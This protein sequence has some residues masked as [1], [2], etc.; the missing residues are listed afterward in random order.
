MYGTIALGGSKSVLVRTP[1]GYLR[2][3]EPLSATACQDAA[4]PARNRSL[5]W[6]AVHVWGVGCKSL[7]RIFPDIKISSDCGPQ[8][9]S[10]STILR[11]ETNAPCC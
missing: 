6:L 4:F 11:C 2:P 1:R 10:K 3:N 7:F 8:L 5:S 9:K